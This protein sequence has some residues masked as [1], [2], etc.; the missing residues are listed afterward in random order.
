MKVLFRKAVGDRG[1]FLVQGGSGGG[2]SGSGSVTVAWG[3]LFQIALVALGLL[4]SDRNCGMSGEMYTPWGTQTP[5]SFSSATLDLHPAQER[6][7]SPSGQ[8]RSQVS[9]PVFAPSLACSCS[10]LSVGFL[11]SSLSNTSTV[12]LLPMLIKLQ[13][14]NEDPL[15]VS[16][17]GQYLM[18]PYPLETSY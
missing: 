17:P 7:A 2:A 1:E 3:D 16:Q 14:N 10:T 4:G 18:C 12:T 5:S 11:L 6:S 9:S 15:K 13:M 8:A